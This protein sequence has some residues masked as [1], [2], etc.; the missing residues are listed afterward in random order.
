MPL[1]FL[2]T[3]HDAFDDW[4]MGTVFC[5]IW[6]F[7]DQLASTACMLNLFAM[8]MDRYW[9]I[10]SVEYNANRT[11]KRMLI[12]VALVW[13]VAFSV[14]IPPLI[15]STKNSDAR[16]DP[17]CLV[18]R[19]TGYI[20]YA[21]SV[22]FYIPYVVMLFTYYKMIRIAQKIAVDERVSQAHFR[23]E[24]TSCTDIKS[25]I[26]SLMKFK[27]VTTVGILIV[28]F[29]ICWMPYFVLLIVRVCLSPKNDVPQEIYILF[30]W[31]GYANS[32]IS[33]LMVILMLN[34]Y[35]LTIK[36]MLCCRCT[37]IEAAWRRYFYRSFYGDTRPTITFQH[38]R[39]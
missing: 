21:A 7:F 4:I 31:F 32:L 29:T 36:E 19:N 14:S 1:A 33:P 8:L 24:T 6:V 38:S 25:R 12:F 26:K 28:A 22:S 16:G 9:T 30:S 18:S 13:L 3:L 2:Y 5:D 27:Y 17:L 34:E 37:M 11:S 39:N 23:I 10:K 20:M 35:R 15:L